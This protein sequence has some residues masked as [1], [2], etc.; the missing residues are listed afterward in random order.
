[1]YPEK[2]SRNHGRDDG[3]K[4]NGANKF[5]EKLPRTICAAKTAPATGALYA[6]EIPD[7]APQA[8]R[9]RNRYGCQFANCPHFEASVAVSWTIAP[10]RPIDPPVPMEM[11][12]EI[13][14]MIAVRNGS[15][16]LLATTTSSR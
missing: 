6:A 8:T 10:S 4:T 13:D 7:A 9:R 1:M 5:I 16:P 11:I 2:T 3:R 12:E 15:R 14:L